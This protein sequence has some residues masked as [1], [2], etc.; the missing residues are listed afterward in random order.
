MKLGFIGCGNMASSIISGA[1]SSGFAAGDNIAVFDIDSAKSA[2]ISKKCGV[3]VCSSAD[4]VAKDCEFTVLAVKPQVFPVVLPQIKNAV[5][6]SKT[7]VVSIAAGKTLDYIGGFLGD[8]PTV[9]VMPNINAM[10]GAAMSAV[11]ANSAVSAEQLGFV[12]ELCK[13]FGDV[14]EIPEGQFSLFSAIAGC[15]PAFAFM[16]IDSL[17]RAAVK[18]GMPKDTALKIAAQATLGSAKMVLESGRH[19]WELTDSVCSPGGTTIEGV[20]SLQADGFEH[21]VMNAVEKALE[22]DKKL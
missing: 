9:R 5:A 10:A 21:A 12:K 20:A 7:V 3:T 22:K 15:S 18:N 6:E 13:A 1:V 14:Q 19:P 17:A 4:A 8:V 16:Y 2:E 11:C